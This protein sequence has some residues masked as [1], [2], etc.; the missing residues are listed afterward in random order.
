MAQSLYKW[1]GN[2][3]QPQSWDSSF[4]KPQWYG[5]DADGNS[6]AFL[7]T[8]FAALCSSSANDLAVTTAAGDKAWVK[9]NSKQAR[10]INKRCR[11]EI[12]KNYSVEDELKA[13]RLDDATVKTAIAAIVSEYQAQVDALVGD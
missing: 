12:R 13:L 3:T 6:F 11:E 10:R 1:T 7:D 4:A 9:A 2:L 8:G 5:T